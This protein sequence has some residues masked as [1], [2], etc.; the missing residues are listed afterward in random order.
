VSSRVFAASRGVSQE[1]GEKDGLNHHI[2]SEAVFV[3]NK[4]AS[5]LLSRWTMYADALQLGRTF[6]EHGDLLIDCH[7]SLDIIKIDCVRRYC[8]NS[9]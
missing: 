6:A 8:A 5:R 3:R 4:T 9:W 7:R 2:V 1:Y